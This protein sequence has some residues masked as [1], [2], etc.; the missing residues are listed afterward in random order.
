[1]RTT[2]LLVTLCACGGGLDAVNTKGP[3]TSPPKTYGGSGSPL[4]SPCDFSGP[5][6]PVLTGST[7]GEAFVIHSDGSKV[8]LVKAQGEQTWIST[9]VARGGFVAVGTT[10]IAGGRYVSELGLFDTGGKRLASAPGSG[11]SVSE[12]G[13]VASWAQEGGLLLL[14]RDGTA[15]VE[16]ELTPAADFGPGGLLPVWK[17]ES[18][19]LALLDVSTHAVKELRIPVAGWSSPVW[20][21]DMLVYLGEA[22]GMLQLVRLEGDVERTTPI[23]A[24][25][26][27]AGLEVEQVTDDFAVLVTG[28]WVQTRSRLDLE[29]G[30][31]T[32]L[33]VKQPEGMLFAGRASARLA[34]DGSLVAAFRKD[35]AAGLFRSLDGVAWAPLGAGVEGATWVEFIGRQ[36]SW[37]MSTAGALGWSSAKA[38]ALVPSMGRTVE[39][40]SP[41]GGDL[42][43]EAL[44]HDGRCVAVWGTDG[45][46]TAVDLVKGTSRVLLQTA[47]RAASASWLR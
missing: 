22:G 18:R 17:G 44:S 24:S 16:P 20:A 43:A 9:P 38:T 37:V 19:Q 36:G 32:P 1:M 13:V 28:S 35:G 41:A 33:E 11:G 40:P 23:V 10:S 8:T 46:L 15:R 4:T 25:A 12:L 39:L 26:L 3:E 2:L 14:S 21:G 27:N 42:A 5:V 30:E 7:A 6:R 47:D 29:T 45:A 31:L 34:D